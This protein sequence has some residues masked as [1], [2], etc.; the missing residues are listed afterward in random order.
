[1]QAQG[2]GRVKFNAG[3]ESTS[4]DYVR[5]T[6]RQKLSQSENVTPKLEINST[7][8]LSNTSAVAPIRSR[9]I[10]NLRTTL[11][12]Q[13]SVVTVTPFR[14]R[15]TNSDVNEFLEVA[16]SNRIETQEKF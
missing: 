2:R 8:K 3:T 16:P 10:N 14:R 15:T 6:N 11:N 5:S 12:S 7:L 13:P 4:S 9:R 1:L